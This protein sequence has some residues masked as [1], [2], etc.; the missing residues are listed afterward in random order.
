MMNVVMSITKLVSALT[1]FNSGREG[2]LRYTN[3]S[4]GLPISTYTSVIF[5]VGWFRVLFCFVLI[6]VS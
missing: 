6:V 1:Q 5:L 4:I 2:E 3:M